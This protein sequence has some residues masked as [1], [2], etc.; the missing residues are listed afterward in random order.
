MVVHQP[1][2]RDPIVVTGGGIAGLFAAIHAA[3]SGNRVVLLERSSHLGGRA[4]SEEQAGYTLNLGPHA[5]YPK[6]RA[7]LREVGV[8]PPG[9]VPSPKGYA[10]YRGRLHRLPGSPVS[11]LTT[12]L[13]GAREKL[14]MARL[15]GGLPKIDLDS[16]TGMSAAEWM[17]RVAPS[18]AANNLLRGITRL[19]TYTDAPEEMPASVAVQQIR[20]GFEGVHYLDGGWQHLVE[21]LTQRAEAL[22]VEL[23]TSVRVESVRVA[24]TGLVVH[25]AGGTALA[26]SAVILTGSPA[27]VADLLPDGSDR[28]LHAWA[29]GAVPV[30]VASLDLGMRALPGPDV[31]VCVG[32]DVPIYYAVHSAT[33]R[34]APEGKALVSLAR[35][36]APGKES[37]PEAAEQELEALMDQLQPGWRAFVE[38]RRFLPSLTVH[39][40]Q[41]R[42]SDGGL[43]G[44]PRVDAA[45][46]PGVFIAGDWVG[47]EGLLGDASLA[48]AR[49]AARRAATA[50]LPPATIEAGS[51]RA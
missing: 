14:R 34:L 25:L 19:T 23:M 11:L 18:P 49:D 48:S 51:L 41:L 27:T 28:A 24:E 36:E 21:L 44:R 39:N 42:L 15:L 32:V 26:A 20:S 50:A 35:Y 8:E 9:R 2:E 6:S 43:A 13:L 10:A 7:M 40:A 22:G 3:G 46:I 16:L 45:G 47:P 29:A 31:R 37:R 30:K 5:L 33:A 4:R 1:P 12:R 17:G 38:V